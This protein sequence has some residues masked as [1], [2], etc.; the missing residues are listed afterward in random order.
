[1]KNPETPGCSSNT[2]CFGKKCGDECVI[3]KTKGWC[4][5]KERCRK[6]HVE[7]GKKKKLTIFYLIKQFCV[8]H[9]LNKNFIFKLK[10]PCR[11]LEV[12]PQR[13]QPQLLKI[14]SHPLLE[15]Q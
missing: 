12:L 14:P 15:I 6:S 7:C 11:L 2:R 13:N 4:D 10:I 9:C 1:M 5:N 8:Q 3:G